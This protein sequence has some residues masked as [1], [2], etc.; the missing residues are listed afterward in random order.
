MSR[1]NRER[2]IGIEQTGRGGIDVT[3][4]ETKWR[5]GGRRCS[6]SRSDREKDVGGEETQK[7]AQREGLYRLGI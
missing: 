3:S 4:S 2:V 1:S 7:E 6:W 5:K